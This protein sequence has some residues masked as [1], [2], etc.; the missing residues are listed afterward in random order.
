MPTDE[1]IERGREV[2]WFEH[3][4]DGAK[5]TF[6]PDDDELDLTLVNGLRLIIPRSMIPALAKLPIAVA[7]KMRLGIQGEAIEVRSEDV[8]VSVPGTRRKL[9]GA[10]IATKGGRA[11]TAAKIE[12]ARAKRTPRGTA[13]TRGGRSLDLSKAD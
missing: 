12:A 11:R 13:L 9:V 1:E 7:K 8:D 2:G 4:Y 6:Y 5:L 10:D 3:R